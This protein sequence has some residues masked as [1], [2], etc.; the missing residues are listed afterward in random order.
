MDFPVCIPVLPEQT[1]PEIKIRNGADLPRIQEG[2]VGV[3][4]MI[5][6]EHVQVAVVIVIKKNSLGGLGARQVEPV[7]PCHFLNSGMPF[8]MPWLM[9]S[10]LLSCAGSSYF[11][12]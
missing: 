7:F 4:G 9:N 12:E 11:P 3:I 6:Q 2:I 8:F 1:V 10:S 5:E